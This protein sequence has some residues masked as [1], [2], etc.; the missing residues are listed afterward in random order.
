MLVVSD[1]FAAGGARRRIEDED[2]LEAAERMGR[3]AAAALS[4]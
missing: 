3:A 4:R 1:T 2:M